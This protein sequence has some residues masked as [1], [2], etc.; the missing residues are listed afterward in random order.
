MNGLRYIR[1]QF[2]IAGEEVS[3]K[4]GVSKQVI[5]EWEYGKN[6][7]VARRD[8]LS[9]I[10]NIPA[11]Y[12]GMLPDEAASEIKKKIADI[13]SEY[14]ELRKRKVQITGEPYRSYSLTVSD[15]LNELRVFFADK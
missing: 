2:G 3:R 11:Q 6:I 15:E 4:I 14:R 10:F 12:L 9:V 1:N 8:Q 7:P 13:S 5:Y